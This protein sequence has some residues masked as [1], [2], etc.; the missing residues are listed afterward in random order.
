[1]NLIIHDDA[2]TEFDEAFDYYESVRPGFGDKFV[3]AVIHCTNRILTLP[4]MHQVVVGMTRRAI[5][6]GFPYCIYYQ[7]I[8]GAVRIVSVFHTSRDPQRWQSRI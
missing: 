3:D 6:K 4:T 8:P 2:T 5:V 7:V 1:M